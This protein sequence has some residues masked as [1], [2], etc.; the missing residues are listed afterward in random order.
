LES[1]KNLGLTDK[2]TKVYVFLLQ[3]GKSAVYALAKY[4]GLKR[5]TIYVVPENLV[6]KEFVYKALK[7]HT[8]QYITVSPKNIFAVAEDKVI[9]AKEALTEL[10]ALC[11]SRK[12]NIS[13]AY[14]EDIE[15]IKEV[16]GQ[17]H[18]QMASKEYV[19]F[20]AYGRHV[21]PGLERLFLGPCYLWT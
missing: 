17:L 15:G 5:P 18:R 20:Y 6:G 4:C 2:E 16:Y 1:L 9:S 3:L 13:I 19:G 14:Y 11:K 21:A 12:K 7:S 10:E 8:A